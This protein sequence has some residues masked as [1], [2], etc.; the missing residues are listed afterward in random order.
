MEIWYYVNKINVPSK[1]NNYIHAIIREFTLC[2]RVDK[3]NTE[4]LKPSTGLCSGCHFNT[5]QNICN[6]IDSILSVRVAKDL[7]R[8]SKALTWLLGLDEIDINIVNSIAPYVISHRVD[9]TDRALNKSP[10]WGNKYKLS[11]ALLKVVTKRFREREQYYEIAD[12][13]RRGEAKS[14]EIQTLN[15][16]KKN[17]LIVK[18]DL[19]PF[20]KS[21]KN[22]Q[23]KELAQKILKAG[24][25]GNIDKLADIRDELME[26]LDFPNRGDLINWCNRELYKQT[27]TDYIFEYAYWKEIWADLSLEFHNIEKSLKEA[28]TR[29]QTRQIR[30][31]DILLE[32]NVTGTDD[33]SLVNIQ[34]SGGSDALKIQSILEESDYIKKS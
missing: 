18:L 25:K 23:Y 33:D 1:V 24:N 11:K 19:V 7:V 10:H 29:R 20:V 32:I 4:E 17:D 34:V 6:K 9:F 14:S 27:V 30:T 8:Y 13:F 5:D 21:I 28:F 3:G 26:N 12:R 31:E 16:I 2:N 22:K 15:K